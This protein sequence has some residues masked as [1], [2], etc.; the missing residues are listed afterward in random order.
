[1]KYIIIIN[2]F[3]AESVITGKGLRCKLAL[4][5]IRGWYLLTMNNDVKPHPGVVLI[6]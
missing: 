2:L 4:A 3:N 5:L 6:Y 1:M